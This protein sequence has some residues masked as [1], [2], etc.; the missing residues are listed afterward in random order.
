MWDDASYFSI[1]SNF[2]CFPVISINVKCCLI[3]TTFNCS[4]SAGCV[5]HKNILYFFVSQLSLS[6]NFMNI[7]HFSIKT[8]VEKILYKSNFA[9]KTKLIQKKTVEPGATI[10]YPKTNLL[11][12]DKLWLPLIRHSHR[13]L[14]YQRLS[15]RNLRR[16][17]SLNSGC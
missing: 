2:R 5:D 10:N 8:A 14:I 15:S 17:G 9:Q 4:Y 7:W 1:A 16:V 6:E 13:K 11:I 3:L 12:T